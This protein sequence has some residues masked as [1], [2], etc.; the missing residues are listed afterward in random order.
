DKAK[1]QQYPT[2]SE[3]KALVEYLL[4]MSTN[5]FPVLVKY[6]RSLALII[7]RQRSVFQV[8]LQ[9]F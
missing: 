4:Q 6:L 8:T 2:P 1:G 5:G 7:A 9:S 3:E